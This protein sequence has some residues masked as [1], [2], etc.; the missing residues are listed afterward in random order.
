M[1][2][3]AE[4]PESLDSW[5]ES[6]TV[7]NRYNYSRRSTFAQVLVTL[8]QNW[9]LIEMGLYSAMIT[10]VIG[11]LHLNPEEALSMSDEQASW[12]GSLPFICHPLA[13]LLLSGYFQDK[14]GRKT[15]MVI[16]TIPTFIAWM[17]LH[18]AQ[19]I[20]VLYMV[21][22]ITGMCTGL[23]EA[24]IHSYIGEVSEPH[25]RGTLSS[26][27]TS[28]TLIGIFVMYVLS[29]L[30]DWRSVALICSASPVITFTCMT[31]IPESPTWL[32]VKNRYEDARKSLCWLRGWVE[33]GKVEEEFQALVK[34]AKDSLRKNKSAQSVG[35]GL[36]KEGGY[37]KTQ[38]KEMTSR[39]VLLPLRLILIVFV[40]R[41]I[42][43]FSAI[44]P[45]LI[46]ELHKLRTPINAKLVLIISE[47]LVFIGAMLNVAFLHRFGKRK[48]AILAN[49]IVALCILGTGVYSSFLQDS[50][51]MPQAAW[52]PVIFW[53][54]LNFFCGFSAVLLPW[55]LV[56][57]I[58]PIAGRGLACG[59]TAGTKYL[60]QSAMIKSYLF[61]ENW[62][63]LSGMMYLYGT[64]AVLGVIHLYFC[65]PETEG[66]TLQQIETYF[67]KNH[68]RK[69][70]YSIG[71]AARVDHHPG[72]VDC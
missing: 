60:I 56:C 71:K 22:A 39:K 11:A 17:S 30:F 13:S 8:I 42:T 59:I 50:T 45:Y 44:R 67:T 7:K 37:L 19:S 52:L 29:Y 4:E 34:H 24:P 15:T 49:G 53:L 26:I 66:K 55:Q 68:D 28:A 54:T 6:G 43:T 65:L 38:F 14:F 57:E 46:G 64:G 51:W 9:L 2:R 70:K 48:I 3:Q 23:T 41:E 35:D 21:S 63:S 69:E 16:V 72:S 20:Y 27:S 33:P 61:I 18:F 1:C 47:V 12:F 31:Q 62:I 36:I 58:F 5:S 40:F 10:T 32:I 25:L